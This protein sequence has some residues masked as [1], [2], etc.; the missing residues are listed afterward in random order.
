MR[1][2]WNSIELADSQSGFSTWENN[3][4]VLTS[5]PDVSPEHK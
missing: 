1:N 4:R 3:L 5:L 2:E